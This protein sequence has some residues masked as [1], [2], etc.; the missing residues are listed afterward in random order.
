MR[1][2]LDFD[3]TIVSYDR[4]FHLVA[5]EERLIPDDLPPSKLGIR[6]YLRKLDKEDAWTEMQG[7]VYGARM[8][9][10]GPFPGVLQALRSLRNAGHELF[11]V[12]HKT[13]HPYRGPAYD[14]HRSATE[15]I[16]SVLKDEVGALI[17]PE[18]LSFHEQVQEKIARVGELAC[19]V[20][21]DDLPEILLAE[22]FPRRTIRILFDPEDRHGS[23]TGV[24]HLHAWRDVG[25][26]IAKCREDDRGSLR[27]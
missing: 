11:I 3:N 6:D 16:N 8:A 26:S 4:V 23:Q 2:G 20:F 7:Y 22:N 15:W 21:V 24:L 14:L 19:D 25:D 18:N 1:I 27:P 10:A 12:S 17:E 5:L 13:R 9:D